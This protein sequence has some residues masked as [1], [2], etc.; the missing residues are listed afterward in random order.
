MQTFLVDVV[1]FT[2]PNGVKVDQQAEVP[3]ELKSNYEDM[4]SHGCRLEAEVLS[5]G[6]V[7]LTVTS[8]ERDVDIRVVDNGPSVLRALQELLHNQRWK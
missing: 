2:R 1:Q 6:H 5:T 3:I 8:E 4:L 7:S